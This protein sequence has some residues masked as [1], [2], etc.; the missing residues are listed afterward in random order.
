MPK[1]RF[2]VKDPSGRY[3]TGIIE[4][5]TSDAA[6]RHLSSKGYKIIEINSLYEVDSSSQL[7]VPLFKKTEDEEYRERINRTADAL[8]SVIEKMLRDRIDVNQPSKTVSKPLPQKEE[9][10]PPPQGPAQTDVSWVEMVLEMP[11]F[12]DR[13]IPP[14]KYRNAILLVIILSLCIFSIVKGFNM[15][16]KPVPRI[17]TFQQVQVLI[18][19]EVSLAQAHSG[20]RKTGETTGPSKLRLIFQFSDVPFEGQ[21]LWKEVILDSPGKFETRFSFAS[22]KIPKRF[23]MMVLKQGY[24][25]EVI[26]GLTLTGSSLSCTVPKII[27]T[28]KI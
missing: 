25:K 10:P 5:V 22:K 14:F 28:P 20:R 27:L 17:E 9:S 8:S 26:E 7:K 6:A 1:F 21:R 4:S 11:P 3:H 15:T 16:P 18:R 13:I 24:E 23:R 2:K 19:G 12:I